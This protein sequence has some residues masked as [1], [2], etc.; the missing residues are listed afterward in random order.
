M[1]LLCAVVEFC[2]GS[3]CASA[4]CGVVMVLSSC[5]VYFCTASMCVAVFV[6]CK[7]VLL[8]GYTVTVMCLFVTIGLNFVVFL[9]AVISSRAE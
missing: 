8:C 9:G 3:V 5:V 6:R 1:T 2:G 7:C 4:R